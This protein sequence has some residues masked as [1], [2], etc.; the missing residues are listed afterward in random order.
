MSASDGYVGATVKIVDHGPDGSRWNLVIVGDGYRAGELAKYHDDVQA[1]IDRMYHTPPF[2]ELWC[3]INVHRIDV[4][5]TDSGADDPM[6]PGSCPSGT[7]ATPA[8]YFDSTFCSW[9]G[10]VR[11]ERLL[12]VDS[13]LAQSTAVAAVPDVDQVLCVVNSAKYGG[14]GGSVATCSTNIQAAEIAIHEIGHSAFGLADEY[15]NGGN[16]SGAEPTQP[17]VTFDPLAAKWDDL[18][19][20]TTPMPSSCYGDCAAGCTPPAVPPA[21]G[22]VGAYEGAYYVHCGAYR[23]LPN[24]YMRDYFPFCPVCDR[25]IRQTLAPFLPAETINLLT[26]S[27]SFTDIPEGIGGTGVTTHRAIVFEVTTCRTLHFTIIAGP[28]GG[29]GTPL[30]MTVEARSDEFAPTGF[31]R[32]WISYTS[33][34]SGANSAGSLTVRLDETGQ[35][36]PVNLSANTVPRPKSAVS[37][38]LDRSGSMSEGAGDG[39]TKVFKMREA[40]GIFINAMLP[41]DGIGLV[42]FDDTAQ[43]IMDVVDVGALVTGVGRMDAINHINGNAFDP[44]GATSIGAGVVQGRDQLNAPRRPRPTRSERCWSCRTESRIPDPCWIASPGASMRTPSRSASAPLHISVA[45]LEALTQGTQGYLVVTGAITPDQSTR[46]SKYF[47]QILAGI[48]NAAVIV[49]PQGVLD[50]EAEHRIPF[51]VTEADYGLDA[52]LLTPEPDSIDY[53]LA[54][55]D[56]SRVGVASAGGLGTTEAVVRDGIAF[57]RL[58]LPA[59]PAS[60]GG[61][62][63]GTWHAVL[64]LGR[65]GQSHASS[66]ERGKGLIPY[67]FVA[68]AYSNLQLR[69]SISHSDYRPGAEVR[70][71]ATLLEYDVPVTGSRLSLWAE[72]RGPDGSLR[73]L[74]G[75]PDGDSHSLRFAT[76]LPGVYSIRV[77]A[78]GET[79]HGGRF[80]REQTLTAVAISGG[81]RPPVER[82]CPSLCT[83]FCRLL[84]AIF[85]P[86]DD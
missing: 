70:I 57:Y 43:R 82:R 80:T 27:L 77:R 7:G 54:T 12:T 81:A 73:N 67:S 26:P 18:V 84:R 65:K 48:T 9:W 5:S 50:V 47:L 10:A 15:E 3:G 4:V 17:N 30:G 53:Q 22:A 37:L 11:L 72:V 85:R 69:V 52:F 74:A 31:A 60:A 28:S 29:F 49:D 33:T 1:I 59:I 39:L 58:A 56:G 25:V 8:T 23:P 16:A 78:Q 36:W 40:A 62:H 32:L 45:A 71:Y 63:S 86:R 35:T 14:A 19:L 6:V 38:V 76:S 44:A 21:A 20:P 46:L 2:D 64:K 41:G 79:L 51:Q 34:T 13:G 75:E 42:R 24:C 61:S 55:P 66:S 83:L 68:H